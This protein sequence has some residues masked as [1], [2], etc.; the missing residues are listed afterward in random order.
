MGDVHGADD[1]VGDAVDLFFF[2]PGEIR[3]KFDVQRGGEHFC[4]EFFG[5]FAG[6]FFGFAEGMVLGEVAVHRF[7]AGKREADAGGD[8]TVRFFGG[9]FA[10]YRERD[11]AGLDV[12]Q[13]FAAGNQFAIWREDGRDADDVACGDAGVSERQ[14]ETRQPFTMFPDAFGEE[15]LL[16]DERHSAGVWCL[17]EWADSKIFP[18]WKSNKKVLQ[19]QRIFALCSAGEARLDERNVNARRGA[20]IGNV[21]KCSDYSRATCCSNFPSGLQSARTF[22]RSAG[23]KSGPTVLVVRAFAADLD[24][25]DDFVA[26]KN[27]CADD[28]LDGLGG[29]VADF[30]AFENRRVPSGGEIVIDFGA[31]FAS[32]ARGERGIAGEWNEADI[33]QGFGDNEVEMAPAQRQIREFRLRR[34]FTPRFFAIR[35]ATDGPGNRAAPSASPLRP[36]ARR[37]SSCNQAH[38]FRS[39]SVSLTCSR[40]GEGLPAGNALREKDS[41]LAVRAIV[42]TAPC[43]T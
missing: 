18:L 20:E 16:R 7:V 37:S 13:T 36:S 5:V 10:D 4:G 26:G 19:S 40:P 21:R 23:V 41:I 22:P 14:L 15:D 39:R 6:Y 43:G 2:V 35:S 33:L 29:F 38:R 9:I 32:S 1:F 8:Q 27:G 24:H 3:I 28:F 42:K 34:I 25:A 17:R 12:L 11:L 30:H 31:A